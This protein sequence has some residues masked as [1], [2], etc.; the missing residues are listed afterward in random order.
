[1]ISMAVLTGEC[2][3]GGVSRRWGVFPG[4]SL[5]VKVGTHVRPQNRVKRVC[6]GHGAG[7]PCVL[8]RDMKIVKI[9]H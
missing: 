1:V 6:F 8:F 9:D 4:G 5:G 3:G 7:H 2:C